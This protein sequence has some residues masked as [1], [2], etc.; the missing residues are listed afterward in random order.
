MTR[1][2]TGQLLLTLESHLTFPGLQLHCEVFKICIFGFLLQRLRF[3]QSRVEPNHVF[4][5]KLTSNSNAQ[6]RLRMTC[7]DGH[8]CIMIYIKKEVNMMGRCDDW[9]SSKSWINSS[10]LWPQENSLPILGDWVKRCK[11]ISNRK[12]FNMR[13]LPGLP[14]DRVRLPLLRF[15]PLML[16][17]IKHLSHG[18]MYV[19]TLA[20]PTEFH[21]GRNCVFFPVASSSKKPSLT[22]PQ[23]SL[24]VFVYHTTYCPMF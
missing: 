7:L 17:P 11:Q 10:V 21:E 2:Q 13:N 14:P 24:D 5:F 9:I 16:T 18:M 12:C 3:D 20:L 8:W 22:S 1:L 19:Y 15:L 4:I 23:H 6:G